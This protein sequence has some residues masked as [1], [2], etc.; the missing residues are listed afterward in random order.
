[1]R[2]HQTFI[3]DHPDIELLKHK[4][5]IV[6]HELPDTTVQQLDLATYVPAA[7][8]AMQPFCEYLREATTP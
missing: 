4:S 8:R 7:F 3:A 2:L 1:M 6:S 5:F